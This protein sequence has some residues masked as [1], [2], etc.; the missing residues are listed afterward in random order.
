MPVR[1]KVPAKSKSRRAP[2][3]PS[4]RRI[5][6]YVLGA[7]LAVFA[8]A[9]IW[10]AFAYAK[11]ARLTDEKL[12]QGPFPNSS[13]LYAAPETVGIGDGGTPLSFAVRLRESGYG[14]DA[15]ANPLGWY[16]VRPDA[17]EI[18]PGD[19]SFTGSE[20]GVLRF[21]DGKI[22]SIIALSDNTPRTEYVLEPQL[23]SSL[24]DKNREKRR[25]VRYDDIPPVLVDAVLSI[26]DKR[27]FQHSGFDPARIAKAFLIDV[28][29]RRNAQGAS[30][31]TQQLARNLWLDPRK[32]FARKFDELLITIHLERKLTKQKIFEY[33]ANQVDLGRRG[34]FAI[35]GFGEASQ[36]YFGKGI[37][38]LT[39]PE[40]ATLAGLIQQPSFR[41]PVR[42]PERAKSRRNVVLRQMLD[43]GYISQSQFESAVATPMIIA[44]QGI[45]SADAPYFVDLVNE[46][47]TE[48]F[49]DH[50]FQ[51]SG[52]RIY[53]TI[54]PQLQRDAAEAVATGMR[55]IENFIAK[56]RK[57]GVALEEP[58]VALICLDP[59]TGEVKALIGGKNYGQSQLDHAVAK[60][61]SGSIFKPFVYAAALNTGLWDQP[62][63]IT[64]SSI[65]PDQPQTFF[66]GGKPY[67]P[68]DYHKGA[69]L[70]DVTLRTA[71]AKSLNVPAVE[72][73]EQTGY[74]AV[75]ALA[76]KAGLADIRATPAMALGA[77]DVTPLEIAGAYT[78]FGNKGVEVSPRMISKIV[79]QTGK[80]IWSGQPETKKILDPR[81]T[82]L[83]LNLMQ[84]VINSGTGAGVR[85]RGF[86]LPAAG[87]TGTSHDAWF[88]GFT[89]KLL[90]VVWVGLDDYQDIKMKGD[91]AA[92][93][94]WTDFMK[95][96]HKHRAYRDVSQ[97]D[98]PDGVVSALID[99]DTGQLATSACPRVITEYY[100]LGTQPVQFCTLHPGGTTEIAG[101][102]AAPAVTNPS[103]PTAPAFQN[104]GAPASNPNAQQSANL[105]N[106]GKNK[107]DGKKH[108]ILDKLKSIFK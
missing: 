108:G 78:I 24:Y 50:D 38:Q 25:L 32:T 34:S 23:L 105:Q 4:A 2:L 37:R 98:V 62:N 10:V 76:H 90:C 30:T 31:L 91:Q 86:S 45:E 59:H 13:L 41:N 100:L 35:R 80:E 99:G 84:A 6:L 52:S 92:L 57:Q 68:A 51:D 55:E 104:P 53:T 70:G 17:I 101:W 82:F 36:A 64:P 102:D 14:E 7:A 40:A 48:E 8:I 65:F 16:H 28:K 67:E 94:I 43:N 63:P 103:L 72:V 71:F 60:R 44:K 19:K 87:K 46:K 58:Q 93:P 107:Q 95:R 11:Y 3:S 42:W 47:L 5:G 39:I 22:S 74:G 66:Y 89:T 77:Y 15:R 27:F 106:D 18:F 33:Y 79:D 54:D 9:A 96:A 1:I 81:V 49:Q 29:E 56:R 61:P 20:P 85:A 21:Q 69:W 26:E 75:A 73:A 83:T 88:A 12:T 97:F